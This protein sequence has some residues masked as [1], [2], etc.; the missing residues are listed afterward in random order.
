MAPEIVN[1]EK[2]VNSLNQ[3][4]L[5]YEAPPADVWALGVV[6]YILLC[7]K[8]PFKPPR[9]DQEGRELSKKERNNLLF[10]MICKEDLPVLQDMPPDV[11]KGPRKLLNKMLIKQPEFRPST[12]SILNDPWLTMTSED[13]QWLQEAVSGESEHRLQLLKP[14]E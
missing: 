2:N 5:G 12:Q 9:T 8:F 1:K 10:K 4:D 3:G 11:S 7:G 13:K 14:P 6:L